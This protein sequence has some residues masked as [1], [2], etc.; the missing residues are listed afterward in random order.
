MITDKK[1]CPR[2]TDTRAGFFI[3]YSIFHLYPQT[4]QQI[5]RLGKG[6]SGIFQLAGQYVHQIARS[7]AEIG[8]LHITAVKLGPVKLAALEAA[9]I[10]LTFRKHRLGYLIALKAEFSEIHI[11]KGVV[12]QPAFLQYV[13]RV[14]KASLGQK[15]APVYARE[16]A[17][18]KSALLRLR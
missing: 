14:G 4:P 5:Y 12:F 17:V 7:I 1:P 18:Y 16:A 9:V 11:R 15:L 6:K 8:L 13:Y 10:Q 2:I 3:Q